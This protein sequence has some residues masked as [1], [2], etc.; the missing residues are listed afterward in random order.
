MG[1]SQVGGACWAG[2]DTRGFWGLLRP[3]VV[4]EGCRGLRRVTVHC[5]WDTGLRCGASQSA[6]EGSP[7]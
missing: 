3:V 4:V 5:A 7:G 1:R 6:A 2:E